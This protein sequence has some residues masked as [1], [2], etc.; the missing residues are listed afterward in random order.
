MKRFN[1]TLSNNER[2]T[3]ITLVENYRTGRSKA[4]KLYM[5]G[6]VATHASADG[7]PL[8]LLELTYEASNST[9]GNPRIEAEKDIKAISAH[10]KKSGFSKELV[11]TGDGYIGWRK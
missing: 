4:S 1:T 7:T 5:Q 10:L 8:A 11:L 6:V 9:G 2:E 3:A